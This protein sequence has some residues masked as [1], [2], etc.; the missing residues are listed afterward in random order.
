MDL[1]KKL[2]EMNYDGLIT[3]TVPKVQVRGGTLATVT[4]AV[5]LERGTLLGVDTSSG[6][7]FVYG[8]ADGLTVYGIL[9]DDTDASTS[10]T[11]AV[12]VYTAGCFDKNKITVADGYT[13]TDEDID[14]LRKYSI[15]FKS[16]SEI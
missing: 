4:E 6:E 16:A 10:E 13:L 5:T 12:T 2:D 1:S 3:D 7:L 8:S 14:A 11:V 9:C 15:V